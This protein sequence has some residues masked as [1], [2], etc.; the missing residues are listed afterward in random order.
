M[1]FSS[2]SFSLWLMRLTYLVAGA[3][4]FIA[5]ERL[6]NGEIEPAAAWTSGL[7]IGGGGIIS[8]VRHSLFHRSD[9]L[10]MQW[11]LGRR[12]N[13]QIEAGFANFAWGATSLAALFCDWG[14]KAQG[15]LI[16]SYGLYIT[17]AAALHFVDVFSFRKDGGGSIGGSLLTMAFAVAL[18]VIG[19]SAIH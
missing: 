10:R 4:L 14:I 9:A 12:N 11:D 18:L 5:M 17:M 6:G 15:A 19:V 7:V 3:G 13:F 1:N 2:P 16:F 8:F